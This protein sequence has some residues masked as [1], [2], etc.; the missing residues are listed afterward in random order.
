MGKAGV[1]HNGRGLH[2]PDREQEVIWAA[3]LTQILLILSYFSVAQGG[4]TLQPSWHNSIPD[5]AQ[6]SLSV[7]QRHPALNEVHS[8]S[9]LRRQCH[10]WIYQSSFSPFPLPFPPQ[11]RLYI[12]FEKH[13]FFHWWWKGNSEDKSQYF[14]LR[15]T[16]ESWAELE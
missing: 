8:V 12:Q 13:C 4:G 14:V 2:I 6:T 10:L 7:P 5:G 11:K 1:L 16:V 15:G 3:G 9:T